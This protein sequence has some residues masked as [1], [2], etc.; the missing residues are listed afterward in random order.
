MNLYIGLYVIVY[1]LLFINVTFENVIF[2]VIVRNINFGV[3]FIL[4][5]ESYF[6]FK[7]FTIIN[8]IIRLY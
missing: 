8:I 6:C 1:H 7:K 2:C 5:F 3:S 4:Y